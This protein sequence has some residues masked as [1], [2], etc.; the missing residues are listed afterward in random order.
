MIEEILI[1]DSELFL[2][3]N[4]LGNRNFDNFWIFMSKTSLIVSFYILFLI[5]FLNRKPFTNYSERNKYIFRIILISILMVIVSDQIPNVSKDYFMRLRPCHN[6]SIQYLL[7]LVKES[8][9]GKFG[10]FSA[11]ASNSFAAAIF[12]GLLFKEFNNKVIYITIVFALLVSYS[13]IYLGVHY[14]LD[15]IFGSIFGIFTGTIFYLITK[16]SFSRL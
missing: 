13:R 3:L 15:I 4:N 14:P 6:E 5:F 8:C 7:R 12:L 9:G 16:K 2:F 10:F 11:H 1:R